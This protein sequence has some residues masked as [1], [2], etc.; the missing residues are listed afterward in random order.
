MTEPTTPTEPAAPEASEPVNYQSMGIAALREAAKERGITSAS[1]M[2]KKEL[3]RQLEAPPKAPAKGKTGGSVP[4]VSVKAERKGKA[5]R[6]LDAWIEG[7]PIVHNGVTLVLEN[8]TERLGDLD[9]ATPAG[10]FTAKRRLAADKAV[11]VMRQN[12]TLPEAS[13]K[14]PVDPELS[15]RAKQAWETRR[16][17]QAELD[18]AAEKEAVAE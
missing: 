1:T 2:G 10:R 14:E 12:G 16:Q 11:A 7:K 9:L 4:Y 3:I 8:P 17:R 15:A 13:A 6:E 5:E 18:A